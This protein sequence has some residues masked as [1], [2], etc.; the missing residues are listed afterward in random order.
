[1]HHD[2]DE[3]EL[4]GFKN[5]TLDNTEWGQ[6]DQ[7]IIWSK[8]Y[9]INLE[10]YCYSM[11]M[12]TIAGDEFIFDKESILLLYCNKNKWCDAE[13]HYD[14]M[15]PIPQQVYNGKTYNRRN[16]SQHIEFDNN[17]AIHI[18]E[19]QKHTKLGEYDNDHGNIENKEFNGPK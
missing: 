8:I 15:Y 18:N 19:K 9:Q 6:F 14:L 7:M 5:R 13:N 1:M 4:A 3:S 12:Q 10:I 17:E 16:E 11:N 2:V